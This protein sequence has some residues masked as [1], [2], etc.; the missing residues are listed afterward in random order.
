MPCYVFNACFGE[1]ALTIVSRFILGEPRVGVDCGI[2][3]GGDAHGIGKEVQLLILRP[4]RS[5]KIDEAL[6]IFVFGLWALFFF[7]LINLLLFVQRT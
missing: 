4:L 6:C 3:L 2:I 5:M 1:D 7:R